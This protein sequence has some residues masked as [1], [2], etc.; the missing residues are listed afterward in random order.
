M[1]TYFFLL[2]LS[3]FSG[4]S[5][6]GTDPESLYKTWERTGSTTSGMPDTGYS[7]TEE[8]IVEFRADGKLLYGTQ[9]SEGGCCRY[10][11]F[12]QK[13]STLIFGVGTVEGGCA[14]VKCMPSPLYS[15]QP[16]TI[17]RLRANQLILTAGSKTIMFKDY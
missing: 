9:K 8:L 2:I 14:H 12:I 7:D 17:E 10:G 11:W 3:L 5:D 1:K 6:S 16:W 15:A 13:E 4:C